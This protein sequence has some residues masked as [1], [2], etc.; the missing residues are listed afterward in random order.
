[1]DFFKL[2]CAI[3]LEYLIIRK[4]V[5]RFVNEKDLSVH[6]RKFLFPLEVF[7]KSELSLTDKIGPDDQIRYFLSERV[8]RKVS[9]FARK[10][11]DKGVSELELDVKYSGFPLISSF[12]QALFRMNVNVQLV[13]WS[14]EEEPGDM[15]ESEVQLVKE[16]I[17][18]S[19]GD[20]NIIEPATHKIINAGDIFSADH[21]L[22][23]SIQFFEHFA[24]RNAGLIG[25]I[26][27][28]INSPL[29]AEYYYN[30]SKQSGDALQTVKANYTLSMLFLRHHAANNRNLSKGRTLL[31]EAYHII[32]NGGLAYTGADTENFYKVFNRNG[33]GLILFREGRS[34]EAIE[35]LRW[36]I[37][38]LS[39]EYNI[40]Y[41]HRSVIMYNICLCYKRLQRFDEA[42]E[43]FKKLLDIDYAFPEYHLEMG[44]CLKEK[45]DIDGYVSCIKNALLVSPLHSD[46]HYLMS[47]ALLDDE[48]Y[49]DAEYHAR[50]AWEVAGDDVTA[51]NYAYILSFNNKYELLDSLL[52]SLKSGSLPEWLIL[53]AEKRAQ[54]SSVEAKKYLLACRDIFPKHELINENILALSE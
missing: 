39:D 35:L 50:T 12:I 3:P 33:Y 25:V 20:L 44:F 26:K 22:E 6:D 11:A 31:D 47:L 27:N 4:T 1:M 52:P 45:G 5:L 8:F 54:V 29:E 43:E 40:H 28:C 21:L 37:D 2:S 7:D 53:Q 34:E 17:K 32:Q 46:S 16:V 36:G 19:N 15:S 10:I 23:H 48:N 14:T 38:Q 51:Y 41:M 30:L 18:G 42:I 9:E 13:T 49:A 24:E